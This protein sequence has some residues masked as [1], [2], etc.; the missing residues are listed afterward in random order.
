MRSILCRLQ[1]LTTLIKPVLSQHD[2]NNIIKLHTSNILSRQKK[3]KHVIQYKPKSKQPIVQLWRGVT[4]L[5]IAYALNRKLDDIF[6]AISYLDHADLFQDANLEIE[7]GPTISSIVKRLGYRVEFIKNPS[8]SKAKQKKIADLAKR[9]PPDPSVLVKRPPVVTIMGHVDHGKTT[10]LD[11]LRHSSITSQEHGGIT[12]HIGAFTVEVP[13]GRIT[14]LDTPGH[15]AFYAMRA[16]GA[17]ATDLVVLVVAVDDGIME[18][19]IESIRFAKEAKVPIIV[20]INKID[21]ADCHIESVK[22]GLLNCGLQV[23]DL[24]G[25]VQAIP[26]SAL[27]KI[28]LDLLIE[29]I[30]TQAE[31]LGIAGDPTGPVEGF[32]LEAS[33]DTSK[34]KVSTAIIQRGT[35]KKGCLLVA[36]TAWAKVRAMYDDRGKLLHEVTPGSPV[37]IFGWKSFPCAG[38]IILEAKFE[39]EVHEVIKYREDKKMEEKMLSDLPIIQKKMEMHDKKYKQEREARLERGRYRKE[40]NYFREKESII[41]PRPFFAFVL[42]GDVHGSVE[43]ILDVVDTYKSHDSCRLDVIHSGVGHITESDVILAETFDGIIYTFNIDISRQIEKLAEEKNVI[44]KP[45]NVIYHLINDMKT[46]ISSKLPLVQ[47]EDILGEATVLQPFLINIGKK[48]VPVG[49]CKCTKGYLKRNTMCKIIR[50]EKVLYNGPVI[51][52]KHEKNDV[53]SIKKDVEC[54]LM[55]ENDEIEFLPGD[56]I[57]CYNPKSVAQVTDWNPPGF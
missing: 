54:G 13:Q 17:H 14:F 38:D 34:G 53:E 39:K 23:E 57:V 44:I 22:H 56:T 55:I 29:A 1:Y 12:Q 41:D 45:F 42:K 43:A 4:P 37:Q 3:V 36:G 32:I 49:G 15:A 24:G 5:E 16:R 19:T 50:S 26:I 2:V 27:K 47:E 33:L 48:K 40:R 46:E 20:A 21:K 7:D 9:P 51:S 11:A 6:E 18:Q 25:E 28:N 52:L 10:L 8:E 30:L 35:L 31:I